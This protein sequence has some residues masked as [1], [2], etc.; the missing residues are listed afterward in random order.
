MTQADRDY[1]ETGLGAARKLI[2]G[3]FAPEVNRTKNYQCD[4]AAQRRGHAAGIPGI[5]NQ[6]R[7]M[8]EAMG[9]IVDRE[10]EHIG[11]S[12]IAVIAARRR[13]IQLAKDLAAG[14]E[15]SLPNNPAAFGVR[16]IDVTTSDTEM[17]D[18]VAGYREKLRFG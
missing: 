5:N 15:L 12:D 10:H 4:L 2:P 6:D 13:L 1:L 9:P 8:I 14:K 18:V 11:T 3:T 17:D 7:A 16:P